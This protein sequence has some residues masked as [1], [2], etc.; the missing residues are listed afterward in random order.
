LIW[1]SAL[2]RLAKP[3]FHGRHHQAESGWA[4]RDQ[5]LFADAAADLIAQAGRGLPRAQQE[6]IKC[7]RAGVSPRAK[8]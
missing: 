8:V 1:P 2:T 5:P 4:G 3:R 7:R 6:L